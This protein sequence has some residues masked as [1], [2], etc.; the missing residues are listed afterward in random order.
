MV[1]LTICV[2]R[3]PGMSHEE[4]DTYWRDVHGPLVK[5]VN[6]FTRHIRRYVQCH[7]IAS[8]I[9]LGSGG[10]YD[11]IAELWFDNVESIERAF[12]E[13]RYLEVIKPDEK[14]FVD[15]E[16]CVSYI[17]EELEIISGGTAG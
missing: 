11:G 16:G 10:Q 1:K 14:K 12:N 8:N 13:P 5:S 6:E 2:V 3:K 4:F 7:G 9:P 15:L 17:S